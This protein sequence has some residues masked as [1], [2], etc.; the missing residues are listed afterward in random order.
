MMAL[1]WVDYVII[2][3]ICLSVITGLFRGFVKELIALTVW[4]LAIWL[5]IKYSS[6]LDPWLQNY[7]HDKTVR[8][9]VGFITVLLAVLIA[10]SLFNALLSFILHRSG[11]SG[12]DRVL[13]MGFGFIRGVFIVALLMLLAKM[14][15]LPY[16]DYSNESRL[17]SKFDPAVN[18]LYGFM[19]EFIKQAKVFDKN[20][21][22]ES[23]VHAIPAEP[24]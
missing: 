21:G 8:M 23:S 17:Y 24:Q 13:G 12:T 10:G 14:S 16:Q 9:A 20:T 15:S 18:W 3:I 19:P 22:S 11:L 2:G 4:V 6:C 7:I 1:H 5:A